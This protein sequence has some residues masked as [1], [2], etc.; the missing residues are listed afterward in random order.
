METLLPWK[1]ICLSDNSR[2]SSCSFNVVKN[3]NLS[4]L[5]NTDVR[6]LHSDCKI[7]GFENWSTKM[8]IAP[9]CSPLSLNIFWRKNFVGNTLL[10]MMFSIFSGKTISWQLYSYHKR[11]TTP[12]IICGFFPEIQGPNNY[13]Q[14]P[15][16]SKKKVLSNF[17]N[18]G[19]AGQMGALPP[20]QKGSFY[21]ISVLDFIFL[22]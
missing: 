12:T 19:G 2:F 13:H 16:R 8:Y 6:L 11:F 22:L 18:G 21:I 9:F 17:V 10:Y 1:N 20:R 4:E 15:A 14:T 7:A 3:I 5:M